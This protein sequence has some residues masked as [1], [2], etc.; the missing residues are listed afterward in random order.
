MSI[1]KIPERA[2]RVTVALVYDTIGASLYGVSLAVITKA[3]RHVKTCLRSTP[4]AYFQKKWHR[5][6]GNTSRIQLHFNR[7]KAVGAW[8]ANH[9]EDTD[10]TNGLPN[11]KDER[12][13]VQYEGF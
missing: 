9:W 10:R 11:I 3:P 7:F 2:A 8:T 4:R 1:V 6:T 13:Y 5:L 12:Y